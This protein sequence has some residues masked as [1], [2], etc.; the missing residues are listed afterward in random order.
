LKFKTYDELN[1]WLT[2]KVIAYAKAHPHPERPEHTIWEMFEE[3]RPKLVAYRGRFMASTLCRLP[4]RRPAWFAFTIT[5]TRSAPA[6]LAGRSRFTLTPVGS[7]SA[8][9]GASLRSIR[10]AMG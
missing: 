9:R 4:C 6:P 8:R 7:S 1:A 3:E 2:D 10:A 5:N